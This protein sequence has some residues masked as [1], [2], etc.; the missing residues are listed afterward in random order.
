MTY[1]AL[2]RRLKKEVEEIV[3]DGIDITG[4][5]FEGP[6]VVIQT[7]NIDDFVDDSNLVRKLAQGLKR[8]VAI[9]PHTSLVKDVNEAGEI[10]TRLVPK[11]A[12]VT[13]VAFNHDSNEVTIE[14][15]SPG[16]AIG[17]HGSNLNEIKKETGWAPQ[18]V[19][20]PPIESKS[21]K[22]IREYLKGSDIT[23]KRKKFLKK[24]GRRIF[25]DIPDDEN[26]VRT[27][28]LGGYREVGRSCHMLTTRNSK[29]LIDIGVNVGSQSKPSPYLQI[30]EVQPFET[31]DAIV[32]THAHLDHSGLVPLMYKYNYDGP[33]YCTAPTR[34]MMALLQLDYIKVAV[35]E[36]KRPPYESKHVQNEILHTI[37]IKYNE[38]TDIAPDIRLTL[39]NAGHILG[40]ASPHFHIGDGLYNIAYSG[41]IKFERTWLF[42]SATNRFPRLETLIMESTYGGKRDFQPTRKEAAAQLKSIMKRTLSKGGKVLIPVFA[43]GRSQEVMVVLEK[44]MKNGQIPRSPIYLDGMIWEATAIHTAYPEFLNNQLRTQIFQ[45]NENPFLSEFFNKVDSRDMRQKILFDTEPCVVLATSGMLNGGP[46]MEYL[47]IW[48]VDPKNTLVF[49][50]YQ[51]EGTLGRKIQKGMSELIISEKG[52]PTAISLRTTS[53]TIDGFSGHSDRK[54]LM[55]YISTM[56]PK[57][58]KIIIHHGDEHKEGDLASSLHRKYGIYTTYPMNLETMRLR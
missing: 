52:K 2:I 31:I 21:V 34:D 41:D 5:D 51:A 10:I 45:R 9:R 18:V 27:T 15:L 25:R 11:E 40:S 29:V 56:D 57:P 28:S 22:D 6:V 38:T 30:S 58:D 49:V 55:N 35:A 53:E 8:R 54:Q 33:I 1:E 12:Q 37:P 48:G 44:L 32:I 43:V 24:V 14:A 23:E 26:W 20:T 16:L 50:G 36:G 42:N 47:R 39:H 3:P 46:V 4:V 7:K 17:K 13:D 19:R